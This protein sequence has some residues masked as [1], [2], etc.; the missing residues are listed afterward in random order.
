MDRIWIRLERIY[1]FINLRLCR[2]WRQPIAF[3]PKHLLPNCTRV[4]AHPLCAHER[5]TIFDNMRGARTEPRAYN[6]VDVEE[7]VLCV[8]ARPSACVCVSVCVRT[9]PRHRR[10]VCVCG[11]R[12][13]PTFSDVF[14]TKCSALCAFVQMQMRTC[15]LAQTH[16]HTH[17]F[18][19]Q[20][21][22][23]GRVCVCVVAAVA[24]VYYNSWHSERTR[25]LKGKRNRVPQTSATMTTLLTTAQVVEGFAFSAESRKPYVGLP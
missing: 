18:A 22:C 8:S 6:P 21:T 3:L 15:V 19:Q 7:S 25:V 24:V 23:T 9:E 13:S 1:T 4:S 5:N 20:L 17:T 11:G 14:G 16:T 12:V 2:R 10:C